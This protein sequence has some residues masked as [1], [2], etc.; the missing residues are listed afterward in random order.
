MEI[1]RRG[2]GFLFAELQAEL[3]DLVTAEQLREALWGLVEAGLVS[4]DGYQAVRARLAGGSGAHKVKRRPQ[5]SR[6]AALHLLPARCAHLPHER[7]EPLRRGRRVY[8]RV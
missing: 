6:S 7:H 5:R 3:S 8:Q 4:P 2:G 1:L